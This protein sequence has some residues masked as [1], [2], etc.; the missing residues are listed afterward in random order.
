MRQGDRFEPVRIADSLLE[1][2]RLFA[3]VNLD[4]DEMAL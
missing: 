1:K 2:D 3:E 4:H